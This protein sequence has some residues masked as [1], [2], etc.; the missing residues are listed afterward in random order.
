[1]YHYHK[2]LHR[3]QP[4]YW[5]N[6]NWHTHKQ[7]KTSILVQGKRC[8]SL[9]VSQWGIP[10]SIT[11]FCCCGFHNK[12]TLPANILEESKQVAIND[13]K[14]FHIMPS[15]ERIVQF[16]ASRKFWYQRKQKK[17][18]WSISSKGFF[19]Q[20]FKSIEV[21]LFEVADQSSWS[22][23]LNLDALFP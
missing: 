14:S 23:E 3:L 19:N 20:K 7:W 4:C 15:K 17:S 2:C 9:S 11:N 5:T 18:R 1:M 10:K 13:P 21:T 22:R 8:K 16:D 12:I 6:F